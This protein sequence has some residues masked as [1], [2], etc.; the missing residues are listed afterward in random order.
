[1]ERR[2]THLDFL[3]KDQGITD[4]LVKMWMTYFIAYVT[5]HG[6]RDFRIFQNILVRRVNLVILPNKIFSSPNQLIS[7]KPNQSP[8]IA[9]ENALVQCDVSS[10]VKLSN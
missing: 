1:M 9:S 4:M 8:Q 2:I 6:L 3:S 10:F 5:W 7:E